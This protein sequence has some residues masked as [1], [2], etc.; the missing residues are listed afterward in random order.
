M[1]LQNVI[2]EDWNCNTLRLTSSGVGFVERDDPLGL[3]KVDLHCKK[4]SEGEERRGRGRVERCG[5]IRGVNNGGFTEIS[6]IVA[7]PNNVHNRVHRKELCGQWLQVSHA[8]L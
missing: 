1:V 2:V 4:G 3:G 7:E 6:S 5:G 8:R